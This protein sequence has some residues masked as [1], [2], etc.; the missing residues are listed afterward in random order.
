MDGDRLHGLLG[1]SRR[2]GKVVSGYM[3][4][5]EAIASGDVKLVLI[6]EDAGKVAASDVCR[7]CEEH[8]IPALFAGSR[9]KFGAALG[10]RPR[11]ALGITDENLANAIAS[12]VRRTQGVIK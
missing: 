2:A 10:T 11:A 8:G 7:L 1:L 5:S 6:A 12:F 9:Q 4:L 3:A